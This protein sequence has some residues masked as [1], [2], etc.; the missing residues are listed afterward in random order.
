VVIKRPAIEAPSSS[1]MRTTLVGS[2][3]PL[4]RLKL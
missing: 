4:G 3:V 2:M 1:A